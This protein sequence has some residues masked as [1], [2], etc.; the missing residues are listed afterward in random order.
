MLLTDYDIYEGSELLRAMYEDNDMIN[1]P[2]EE[3]KNT[4]GIFCRNRF[5]CSGVRNG[6]FFGRNLDWYFNYDAVVITHTAAKEGRHASIGI[7]G[8]DTQCNDK[9]L[10]EE[11]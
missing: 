3:R 2:G 11:W 1:V 5:A 9:Y 10:A 4:K 8:T 7:I 6:N